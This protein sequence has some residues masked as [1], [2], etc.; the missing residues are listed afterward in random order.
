MDDADLDRSLKAALAVSPSPEFVAR[1]RSKIAQAEPA[2]VF[3]WL[4]PVVVA[5]CLAAT[6]I[7]VI[8]RPTP[9]EISSR[10]RTVASRQIV[11]AGQAPY[12]TSSRPV[13]PPVLPNSAT[14]HLEREVPEVLIAADSRLAFQQFIESAVERRFEATFD[15]TP[16]STPWTM[17]ELTV[18]P[19]TIEPLNPPAAD[20]N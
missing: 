19:L 13:S 5:V 18:A 9:I 12:I 4:K 3:G 1:V 16:V 7:A 15:E 11:N 6:A 14:P 20:N 2:P 10:V 8:S 17:T